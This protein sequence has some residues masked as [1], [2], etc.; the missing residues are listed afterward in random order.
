LELE[1]VMTEGAPPHQATVDPLSSRGKVR[2]LWFGIKAAISFGLIAVVF[3][4]LD[5]ATIREKSRQLSGALILSVVLMFSAQIY[6]AAWRW[7]LILRHHHL[8][9]RL[10]TTLRFSLI[11]AFFNQLLPS[12]IGGD[13]ARAWYVYRYCHGKR[14]SVITV[15]SDRIY[16]MLALA[17]LAI[18]SFPILVYYSVS[19]KALIAIGIFVMGA[20]A[21]LIAVFWLDCLPDWMNRWALIRHLGALSEATRAVTADKR[22]FAPLVGLSFLIHA[23]TILAT[24]VL[25]GAVA[26]QAHLLL[27]AALVPVIM[28]MAIVPVSIA[29]WGVREGVMIYGLGLASVSPEAALIVSILIGLSLAAVGLLGG[30]TWLIQTDRD[31]ARQPIA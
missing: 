26:P 30:V 4:K 21:A 3:W 27:C 19:V 13:V 18:I 16:G 11:G 23:I 9:I 14:I 15:I 29:G 31:K 17:C 1:L 20:S 8:G 5:F 12:S 6:V 2:P 24:V 10:L 7:W 22:A 28:L 25:L